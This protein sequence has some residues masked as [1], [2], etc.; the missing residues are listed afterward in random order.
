MKI[1][2]VTALENGGAAQACLRLHK[3]LLNQNIE[4]RVL[5]LKKLNTSDEFTYG[6]RENL[7]LNQNSYFFNRV[8]A[9]LNKIKNKQKLKGR[10]KDLDIFSFPDSYF[11]L[12][13]DPNYQQA[14]IIHFHWVA[15]FLD[16]STFFN[17]TKK[18]NILDF[19]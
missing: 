18:K 7:L 8:L 6:Y 15:D 11:N 19:A 13:K 5:F 9:E 1:L 4:S 12:L 14:D 3:A 16:Y 17:N 10:E 2:H